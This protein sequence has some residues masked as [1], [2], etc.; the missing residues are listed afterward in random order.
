MVGCS[1][2]VLN[3]VEPVV[4]DRSVFLQLMQCKLPNLLGAIIHNQYIVYA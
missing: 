4:A 1:T 2:I 3:A